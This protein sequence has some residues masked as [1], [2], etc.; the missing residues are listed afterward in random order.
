MRAITF[1]ILILLSSSC[2]VT[3][4]YQVYKSNA[5]NGQL[6]KDRIVFEDKNC[7]VYYNLWSEGGTVEFSIFNKSESEIKIDL[8]KSFFVLNGFANEYFQNRTFSNSTNHGI[9]LT[10]SN[11][12]N[13][14]LN[15][16]RITSSN[17]VNKTIT[18]QEKPELTIPSKTMIK[19]AEFKVTNSRYT[20]CD[21]VK[22]PSRNEIST[23]KFTKENSPFVFYN[24]I[25]YKL[26][27]ETLKFE[28]RF[29]V[30]EITN[31]PS[32]K[33]FET[34]DTTKCGRKLNYPI[35]V[36]KNESPDKF[37]IIYTND[38]Y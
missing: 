34:I 37:F 36:Y 5:E 33:M 11:Q 23:I 9:S 29:Y 38:I 4:Y 10:T 21:L 31:L 3:N 26:Q 27:L 2:A 30:N 15:T 13:K 35:E 16:D 24:V 32:N 20:N 6:N 17:S 8:T 7:L 12:P 22:I 18:Y 28:N 25:S 1:S 19:I 14:T